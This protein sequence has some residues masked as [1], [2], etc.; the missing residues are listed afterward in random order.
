M[1]ERVVDLRHYNEPEPVEPERPRALTDI[2]RAEITRKMFPVPCRVTPS[3]HAFD[4]D[5][6][7]EERKHGVPVFATVVGYSAEPDCI[8]V[9]R[10]G[11]KRPVTWHQL[12]WERT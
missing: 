7:R 5:R 9:L 1:S 3:R 11:R 12:F 8:R 6:F 10:D 2:E 4:V